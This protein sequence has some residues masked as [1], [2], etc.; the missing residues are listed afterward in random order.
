MDEDELAIRKEELRIKR[1]E[2]KLKQNTQNM[3]EDYKW[4]WYIFIIISIITSIITMIWI[5]QP[6]DYGW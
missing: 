5:M 3:F 6:I 2:L 4:C 1:E